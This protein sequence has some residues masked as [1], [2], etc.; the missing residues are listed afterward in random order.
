MSAAR[1][2]VAAIR[3]A[4]AAHFGVARDDMLGASRA[5]RVLAAR[6]L[7]MALARE[8]TDASLPQIARQFKRRHPSVLRASAR[9]ER[10]L[11]R[12]AA[13]L[14]RLLATEEGAG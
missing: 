5:P 7:A 3:D 14:R 12:D 6:Q 8:L 9:V 13:L 11:Q 1:L 4:V 10:A 2:T